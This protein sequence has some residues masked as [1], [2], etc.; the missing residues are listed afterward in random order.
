MKRTYTKPQIIDTRIDQGSIICGSQGITSNPEG[1]TYG[2]ID[3]NG[4]IIPEA[5][6]WHDVWGD[7]EE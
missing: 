4:N 7:D 2:G 1:L 5:R 6:S 3:T